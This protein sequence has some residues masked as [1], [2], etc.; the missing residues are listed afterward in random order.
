[1]LFI[2]A[3]TIYSEQLP[4]KRSKCVIFVITVFLKLAY[5]SLNNFIRIQLLNCAE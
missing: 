3:E 4:L 1:M 2:A 5:T